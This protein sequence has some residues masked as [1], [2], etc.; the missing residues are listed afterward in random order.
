LEVIPCFAAFILSYATA[1]LIMFIAFKYVRNM[2]QTTFEVGLPERFN[3]SKPDKL[4][5]KCIIFASQPG[6][7]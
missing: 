5:R 6:P 4:K 7:K 1:S 3:R 2:S